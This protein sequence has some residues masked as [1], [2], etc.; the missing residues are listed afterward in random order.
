MAPSLS[1]VHRQ[2]ALDLEHPRGGTE[3]LRG[4]PEIDERHDVR[5]ERRCEVLGFM[6]APDDKR[7]GD[8]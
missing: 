4:V 7:F 2:H 5:I 1:C 8:A 3:V 6:V